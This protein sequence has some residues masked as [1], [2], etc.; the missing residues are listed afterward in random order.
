[1]YHDARIYERQ[2]VK[3]LTL[4]T[5]IPLINAAWKEGKIRKLEHFET[6]S[7]GKMTSSVL[8]VL[9]LNSIAKFRLFAYLINVK[10]SSHNTENTLHLVDKDQQISV[11]QGTACFLYDNHKNNS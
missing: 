7:G 1:L 8:T 10:I 2:A 5:Y 9:M 3:V 6:G 11:D 4:C